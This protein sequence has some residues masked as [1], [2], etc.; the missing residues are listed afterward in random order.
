MIIGS[1][2][3][4]K[5]NLPSTNTYASQILRTKNSKEGTVIYTNYQSAG[6]GYAGNGWESE[7]GKNLLF[8][9]LLYPTVVNPADQFII[10]M[11]ISLGICDFLESHIPV[12]RVKWPNDI[13]VNNDKIAGILIENTIMGNMLEDSVAG[14]GL[15]LNQVK[16]LSDAPNPV[17]LKMITGKEYDLNDSL[18]RLATY[19][20]KRYKQVLSEKFTQLREEYTSKLFRLNEWASYRDGTGVFTGRIISVS[21]NG[22][23]HVETKPGSINEYSFKEVEF[24][25]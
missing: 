24:I 10:S 19:L 11:A 17:S 14:I 3:I 22:R 16:F 1:E 12:C 7:D 23:L 6:R 5:A 8:S 25:I 21:E 18:L 15:N 4:F 13:Y 20:D 2:L 9:I